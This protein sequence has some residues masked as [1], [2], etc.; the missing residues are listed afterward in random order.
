MFYVPYIEFQREYWLETVESRLT[1]RIKLLLHST[2]RIVACILYAVGPRA[3]YNSASLPENALNTSDALCV[4]YALTASAVDIDTRCS[5][6]RPDP[7]SLAY[8]GLEL[9]EKSRHHY[10]V[11]YVK[12]VLILSTSINV[13]KNF[14][15]KFYYTNAHCYK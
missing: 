12:C 7:L 10:A 6:R 3:R 2:S 1:F 8:H 11:L 13:E 4:V 14:V 5:N 9:Y 15:I